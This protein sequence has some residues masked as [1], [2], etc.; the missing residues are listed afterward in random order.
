[1]RPIGYHITGGQRLGSSL[2]ATVDAGF[3]SAQIFLGPPQK[4]RQDPIPQDEASLFRRIKRNS[5]IKVFVHAPYVLHA[6]AKPEN[7]SK[8]NAFLKKLVQMASELECDGFVLH[9]GGTKWYEPAQYHS[10][11]SKL[12]DDIFG[13]DEGQPTTILF[14]NCANGNHMSGDIYTINN[15]I[16]ELKTEGHNVGLCLDTLH[17][18]AYGYNYQDPSHL[19]KVLEPRMLS[20]LKLI[21]LNSGPEKASCGSKFDRHEAI[22]KGCIPQECF[23]TL[24]K[25]LPNIPVIIEG[26]EFSDILSDIAFVKHVESESDEV[27]RAPNANSDITDAPPAVTS[28]SQS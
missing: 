17:A 4:F 9:M 1:M 12:F 2:L 19:H 15:L 8:N 5:G 11:A 10:V 23:T 22:H 27:L 7:T 24:L 25:A 13:K 14:E 20:H 16:S 26:H 6:F 3:T 18:W 21:H 28:V